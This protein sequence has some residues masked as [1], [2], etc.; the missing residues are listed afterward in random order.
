MKRT[1]AAII[2]IITLFVS[3]FILPAGAGAVSAVYTPS[4]YYASSVYC[5]NLLEVQ[6][7]GNQRLDLINIALSQVGYHEG[8]KLSQL[9]GSNASG[10]SNYTE[11]G[12]WFGYHVVGQNSG[13]FYEWCAMFI[14]WSAR[15]ARIPKSIINNASY[16]HAGSNP[17]YFNVTYHP[18][19]SYTPKPGDLVFYDWV[20]TQ[21][22]WDHVG[23]V[24]YTQGGYFYAVEGNASERVL[25]RKASIY[26]YEVQGFGAP[27]YTNG[28]AAAVNVSSYNEPTRKLQYGSSGS[29]VK[30]LQAALL[31]LGYPCPIDGSF[32]LN[33][34][35]QL[36]KF[37]SYCGIEATGV[38]GSVTR[39]AIKNMLSSGAAPEPASDPTTFPEPTRTLL[40]GMSGDDV[41]WLQ[42]ALNKVGISVSVTGY[43]GTATEA[44]V[45]T[46]Q[47]RYGLVQDGVVGPATRAKLKSL[48]APGGS[49]SGGN[50]A[51]S[52]GG[53]DYPEPTRVLGKGMSGDDVKWLQKA[54]TKAGYPVN[55]TGYFG[56]ATDGCVRSFQ[57]DNG[58]VQDGMVG[59]VTR[60]K[61]KAASASGG[62]NYPEPTRN[63]KKGLKG[64]D[65]KWLQWMLTRLGYTLT[66]DGDFGPVTEKKVR[67]FQQT[68]GLTVDGIAGPITRKA[69]KA[70]AN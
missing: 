31:H 70:L 5:S 18:R 48:I 45:K 10:S 59:P 21:K 25:I 67:L 36:K 49:G 54:L 40:R 64:E 55:I 17:Y 19:G 32:G 26:S 13:F 34:K 2:S 44:S 65:V 12:Y 57:R 24:L 46:L 60:A 16:A 35:R 1:A 53:T 52:S 6:L 41:K 61:L 33:T 38:C 11:Y 56:I 22:Q 14:A 66:I 43:F 30:W 39:S 51:G 3:C 27:A 8:N 4:S 7:T 69:L 62:T 23:I 20:N 68:A 42:T 63:L 15:Q 9:D 50:G 58:L 29:D 47:G 28:N 37:Q